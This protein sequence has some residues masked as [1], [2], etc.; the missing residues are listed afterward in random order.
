MPNAD[1]SEPTSGPAELRTGGALAV[2]I[3]GN[4]VEAERAVISVFDR[5]LLYGDGLFEVLRTWDGVAVD[6]DAHLD[7]LF[8]SARALQFKTIER[9][10]LVDAVTRTLAVAQGSLESRVATQQDQPS[11]ELRVRIAITR[12]PGPI[13]ARLGELGLGR[14]IV[15]AEPLP[16]QPS[17]VALAIVD[18]PLPQRTTCGHKT[19]A[20][21][22]HV[23]ARELAA[24]IGADEAV[25]LDAAGWV[26][27]GATSN[28]FIVSE[29]RVTTPPTHTGALP[30][31]T[32]SRVLACCAELAIPA[33]EAPM[34]VNNL[35]SADE[36][37]I[38]SAL[39]GVSA[40]T[41]VDGQTRAA[42]PRTAVLANA[43]AN[44]MRRQHR[45]DR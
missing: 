28:I 5:G 35:H 33:G 38:T 6:L 10:V 3:D 18:W 1:S 31:I 30:G 21:I 20:Y 41:R 2:S 23:I 9:A 7:R 17:E 39:R 44:T 45:R 12:G 29:G 25:R 34:R 8:A 27:E 36:I 11:S 19:L 15:I 43:Y 24:H 40:V 22:D 13:G 37:F 32:R 16:P 42:G 14:S 26:V 4:V